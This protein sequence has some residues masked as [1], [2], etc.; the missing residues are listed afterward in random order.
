MSLL[1]RLHR[2]GGPGLILLG[3]ADN[4]LIPLTGSMDVFTIWLAARHHEPWPYYAFM[5]TLGAV[6]GGYITYALACKGGKDTLERKL[7][8]R[9]ADKVHKRFER[10]GFYALAVPAILPGR[11]D[12]GPRNSLHCP[13]LARR[14]VWK[15]HRALLLPVL[16]TCASHPDRPR[17]FWRGNVVGNLLPKPASKEGCRAGGTSQSKSGLTRE[18]DQ[19]AEVR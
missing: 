6:V 8:K 9:T 18:L 19:I 10:W 14:S 3:I 17:D 4:S 2:M 12:G 5:A 7:S 1:R 13:G 15:S 16:Q 11:A